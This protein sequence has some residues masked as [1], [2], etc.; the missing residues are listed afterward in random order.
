M[1]VSKFSSNIYSSTLPRKSL[2]TWHGNIYPIVL[3]WVSQVSLHLIPILHGR[4]SLLPS[5]DHPQSLTLTQTSSYSGPFWQVH[6]HTFPSEFSVTSFLILFFP[7]PCLYNQSVSH[8]PHISIDPNLRL[9]WILLIPYS[10]SY[11]WVL[12]EDWSRGRKFL[13][14]C[15][16]CTL[17]D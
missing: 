15:Y 8:C 3:C 13:D 4:S 16:L 5:T 1:E 7:N 11:L 10:T 6:P 12:A 9:W 2:H 14:L 17:S